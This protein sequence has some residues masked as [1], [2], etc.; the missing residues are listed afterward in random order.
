MVIA[1]FEKYVKVSLR[2]ICLNSPSKKINLRETFLEV[3]IYHSARLRESI[4]VL[5]AKLIEFK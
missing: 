2:N 4:E 1:V 3:A 5:W